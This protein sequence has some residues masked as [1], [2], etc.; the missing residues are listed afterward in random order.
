MFAPVPKNLICAKDV[1]QR[2]GL[3]YPTLNHY[4]N[5]GFFRLVVKKGNKRFYQAEEVKEKLRVIARM[6]DDGYPLRLIRKK[7][8]G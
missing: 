8:V 5:L 3:S 2:F 1:A 6:K 7:L 4:T